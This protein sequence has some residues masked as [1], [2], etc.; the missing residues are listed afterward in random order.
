MSTP[1]PPSDGGYDPHSSAPTSGAY[2]GYPSAPGGASA[3]AGGQGP[4]DHPQGTTILVLG[5]L[6]LVVC[7]ILAPV[8]WYMGNNA[9]KEVEANPGRYANAQNI[10]IGRILGMIGTALIVL[11]LVFAAI[12]IIGAVVAGANA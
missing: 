10:K 2:G 5:I 4:I 8:A 3:M 12:I 7:S 1:P 9:M 6:G 11:A